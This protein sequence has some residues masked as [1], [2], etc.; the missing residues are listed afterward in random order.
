MV[1]DFVSFK[2]AGTIMCETPGKLYDLSEQLKVQKALGVPQDFVP[3]PYPAVIAALFLPS[4]F[5]SIGSF[6]ICMLLGNL[7][8]LFATLWIAI[9]GLHLDTR[10]ADTVFVVVSTAFPVY[11]NL[12]AGQLGFLWLLVYLLFITDLMRERPRAGIWVGILILKPTLFVLPAALLF[13]R[14]DW[15]ALARA[16]I[17]SGA[18][19][20]LSF[21][22]VGWKATQD[23]F[24]LLRAMGTNA[25]A[26]RNLPMMQNLRALADY[27][28]LGDAGWIAGSSLVILGLAIVLRR[29]RLE[30]WSITAFLIGCVLIPPHMHVYDLVILLFVPALGFPTGA[31]H[32]RFYFLLG[33]LPV[34]EFV[35]RIPIPAAPAALFILFWYAV[36][37]ARAPLPE[38]RA[39][40]EITEIPT[41]G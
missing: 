8:L 36:Y 23:Y 35:L 38:Q 2:A 37:R 17:V 22:L 30:K 14:R 11:F 28:G 27:L 6:F 31:W 29:Q 3:F 9:R 15:Q 40:S 13:W 24:I 20:A 21:V 18:L 32:Q 16:G 10:S 4:R 19:A 5:L 26:L 33:V 41:I 25:V 34:I 39:Q 12:V 7:L 1:R